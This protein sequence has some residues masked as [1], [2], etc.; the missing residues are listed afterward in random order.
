MPRKYPDSRDISLATIVD[1][2]A[3]IP[4]AGAIRKG[5]GS[6]ERVSS[7]QAAAK[8]EIR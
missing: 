1:P 6:E 4:D 8:Q 3:R 2:D 5:D 7:A